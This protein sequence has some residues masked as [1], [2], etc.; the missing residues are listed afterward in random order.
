ML[1]LEGG[2]WIHKGAV[3]LPGTKCYTTSYCVYKRLFSFIGDAAAAAKKE[4]EVLV[5]SAF[6]DVDGLY[7]KVCSLV[8]P[9]SDR[10]PLDSL[11]VGPSV[12]GRPDGPF[13]ESSR[14]L[15]SAGPFSTRTHTDTRRRTQPHVHVHAH[16][17]TPRATAADG[18]GSGLSRRHV[19]QLLRA[20]G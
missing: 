11:C 3:P 4:A 1:N 15:D 6:A 17:H 16:A 7:E 2:C 14:R 9:H 13:R 19:W 10:L 12:A 8:L 5:V 18:S 20:D